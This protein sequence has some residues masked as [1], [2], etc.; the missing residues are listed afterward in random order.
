MV[1]IFTCYKNKR[2]SKVQLFHFASRT[3]ERGLFRV[4]ETFHVKMAGA[5]RELSSRFETM[6]GVSDTNASS[7]CHLFMGDRKISVIIL[8]MYYCVYLCVY[9]YI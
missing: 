7:N 4:F 6:H 9:V 8:F 2:L 1:V 5:Q 3:E